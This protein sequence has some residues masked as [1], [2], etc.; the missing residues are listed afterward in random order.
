MYANAF[1]QM[2]AKKLFR[3]ITLSIIQGFPVDVLTCTPELL[4]YDDKLPFLNLVLVW[5]GSGFL[6]D[7]SS[8]NAL[9]F[10]VLQ[11]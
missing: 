9:L 4:T 5:E 7:T 3:V 6:F 11:G 1:I 2:V 10:F 8:L